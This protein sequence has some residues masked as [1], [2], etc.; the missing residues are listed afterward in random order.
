MSSSDEPAFGTE[1]GELVVTPDTGE[2]ISVAA[3]I[4]KLVFSQSFAV[5]CT[6]GQGQP[7]GSLVAMA[8]TDDL[9]YAV[10]ATAKDTRKFRLLR[11]CENV[12]LLIDNRSDFPGELMKVEA[13]TMTGRALLLGD[14]SE[15]DPWARLLVQRHPQLEHFVRSDQT[16]LFRIQADHYLHVR[17]FQET[18]TWRPGANG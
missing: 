9:A 18:R 4:K 7:Y 3:S 14:R 17:Q 8:A 15:T 5:L 1:D 13:V 6:Q 11:E 10:F 2:G 12:A 16:G